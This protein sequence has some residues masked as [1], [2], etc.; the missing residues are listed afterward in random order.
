M[1]L[2]AERVIAEGAAAHRSF[3]ERFVA[4][5]RWALLAH[6]RRSSMRKLIV[7]TLLSLDGV[8]EDPPS[9]GSR[10]YKE[11]ESIRDELGQVATCDAMLFGRGGYESLFP[12]FSPRKD[13]WAARINAMDKF[14]FSSTLADTSWQNSK[15]VRGDAADAVEKMKRTDGGDLLVYGYTRFSESLLRKGLVD[16][17][18]VALHPVF[19]GRG[20]QLSS[21]GAA[22]KMRLVATKTYSKGVVMLSYAPQD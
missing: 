21:E 5:R 12:I 22:T 3:F 2:L 18:R 14:V 19:V 11:D 13:A 8:F 1:S 6:M 9:W 10:D 7:H 4:G 16:L 20:R 17:L 15:L